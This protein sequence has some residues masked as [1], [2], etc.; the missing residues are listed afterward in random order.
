MA[1]AVAARDI[2]AIVHDQ[3]DAGRVAG[4]A[5][6]ASDRDQLARGERA[7]LAVLH[8]VRAALGGQPRQLEV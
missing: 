8:G 4:H 6:R 5:H 3:R 1:R 7:L 2:G